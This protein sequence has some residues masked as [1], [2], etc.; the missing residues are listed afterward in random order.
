MCPTPCTAA[1]R[2][3][4]PWQACRC[5]TT[6]CRRYE[7]S[8]SRLRL[9]S[10]ASVCTSSSRLPSRLVVPASF[11][12][13][14]SRVDRTRRVCQQLNGS[15]QTSTGFRIERRIYS[16]GKSLHAPQVLNLEGR[17]RVAAPVSHRNSLRPPC[18][19]VNSGF[20]AP[21][22]QALFSYHFAVGE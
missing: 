2:P 22:Y 15:L 6:Y 8:P 21:A 7:G 1:S 20:A 5:R 9:P 16:G 10:F 18:R 11:A 14:K 17:A 4:L 13:R 3:A 19:S 12:K